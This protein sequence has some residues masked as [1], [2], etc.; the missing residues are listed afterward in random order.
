LEYLV[1]LLISQNFQALHQ[2]QSGVN[3]HR[4]LTSEDRELLGIHTTAE[5]RQ[6]EFLALLRHFSDVDLLASQRVGE[7]RLA[8]RRLLSG[9]GCPGSNWYREMLK[10]GI[11][12]ALLNIVQ[13]TFNPARPV[14]KPFA[15]GE[16]NMRLSILKISVAPA[17]ARGLQAR[18]R[19][20]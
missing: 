5:C 1:F 4:E 6:A 8:A 9:D 16:P 14:L 2:R 11:V 20:D 10:T 15:S 17:R 3:H 13:S 19:L 12:L 7:F 18:S